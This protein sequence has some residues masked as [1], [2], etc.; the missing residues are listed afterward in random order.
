M[1]VNGKK[2]KE[3]EKEFAIIQMEINMMKIGKMIR[4][5]V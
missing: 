2:I 1:M 4:K 3:K 5:K